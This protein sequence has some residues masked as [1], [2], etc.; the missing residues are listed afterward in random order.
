MLDLN[1]L[2]IHMLWINKLIL[3]PLFDFMIGQGEQKI[4][5]KKTYLF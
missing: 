2:S 3:G 1:R 4:V 5:L